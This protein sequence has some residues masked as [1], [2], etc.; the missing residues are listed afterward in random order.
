MKTLRCPKCR[1][2][3]DL[4]GHCGEQKINPP[5]NYE[6][7][8]LLALRVSTAIV[9][10]VPAY[11]LATPCGMNDPRDTCL[12]EKNLGPAES[13]SPV[14]SELAE[15][16]PKDEPRQQGRRIC[17]ARTAVW[18]L[19]PRAKR[20]WASGLTTLDQATLVATALH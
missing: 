11:L 12:A 4:T 16:G 2:W 10:D 9:A 18:R 3:C 1:G 7:L 13:W 8:S 20:F 15:G 17:R 5:V 19:G 6:T 14:L